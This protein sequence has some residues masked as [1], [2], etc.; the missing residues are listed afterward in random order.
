ML[1]CY[2]EKRVLSDKMLT[3]PWL[4][5]PSPP[6]YFMYKRLYTGPPNSTRRSKPNATTSRRRRTRS[7]NT[8]QNRKTR[9]PKIM[10][11]RPNQMM[12]SLATRKWETFDTSTAASWTLATLATGMASSSKNW[13]S[14]P[15]G[16]SKLDWL[17]KHH[18]TYAS[19]FVLESTKYRVSL[20]CVC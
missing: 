20:T 12:S 4:H 7:I 3:H 2:P 14:D 1:N 19:I 8:S 13:I 17:G 15:I 6:Q 16:S 9:R 5:T 18:Q 10:E 11:M